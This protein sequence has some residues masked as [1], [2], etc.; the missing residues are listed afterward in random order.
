MNSAALT[1]E[2]VFEPSAIRRGRAA[3]SP[4]FYVRTVEWTYRFRRR[5]DAADFIRNGGCPEHEQV[6][7]YLVCA[8][9]WGQREQRTAHPSTK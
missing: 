5:K 6:R 7:P 1:I 9:C 4:T 8:R 2:R 3:T